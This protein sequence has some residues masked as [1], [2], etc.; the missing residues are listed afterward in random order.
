MCLIV[1]GFADGM[2]VPAR[3][4]EAILTVLTVFP[5]CTE[6][7]DSTGDVICGAEALCPLV[8]KFVD[9]K[10]VGAIVARGMRPSVTTF[11]ALSNHE[12]L[13]TLQIVVVAIQEHNTNSPQRN[14]V[15]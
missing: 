13:G 1:N 7:L 8:L 2:R 3:L 9:M 14:V 11:L 15:K 12:L 10:V 5:K 6:A 4:N